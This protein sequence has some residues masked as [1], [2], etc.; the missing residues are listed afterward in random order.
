LGCLFIGE[1]AK[2]IPKNLGKSVSKKDALNHIKKCR[3]KGLVHLIGRDKLDET[4]LGVG[5]KIPLITV[6]NCCNCC[7]L[8]RML[9]DL[10][11]NLSSTVKKMPGVKLVV[12][13][14]CTA[15]KKCTE[16]VCFINAIKVKN[17]KAII[18]NDCLCCGRCVE[19]CPNNAIDLVIDDE[20][21]IQK[22]IER[23]KS[24]CS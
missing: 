19:V 5:S 2:K 16:E 10:H 7:C 1:A 14:N 17:G 23:V 9:P 15:C 20:K 3:E 18:S 22:T 13:D 8:W 24:S 21:F 4:W 6:C 12:N 11:N